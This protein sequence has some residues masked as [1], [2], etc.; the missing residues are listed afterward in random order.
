LLEA[1]GFTALIALFPP[2]RPMVFAAGAF[3]L[4]L[5]AYVGMLLGLRRHEREL[6]RMRE[7]FSAEIE[8]PARAMVN[9][10][11]HA[12]RNGNGNGNG[13]PTTPVPHVIH[14]ED[15]HVVIRRARELQPAAR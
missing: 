6:G 2:L 1:T 11:G 12:H 8:R 9:G 15:V 14:L 10:N 5:A 7:R 4:L 3:G 13:R